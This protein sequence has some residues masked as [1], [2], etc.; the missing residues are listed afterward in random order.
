MAVEKV[1]ELKI[2]GSDDIE[3]IRKETALLNEEVADLKKQS[4]GSTDA[5]DKGAKK[6]SKSVGGLST[7]FKGLGLVLKSLGIGLILSAIA[8]LGSAFS[9]NQKVVDFFATAM[10]AFNMVMDDFVNFILNNFPKVTEFFKDVFENPTKYIKQLGEEIKANLN[11]RFE[12]LLEVA[13]FLSSA[14]VKLFKGDFQGALDSVKEAGKELVDAASGVDN[15]LQVW[16]DAIEKGTDAISNY[17]KGILETSKATVEL[18]NNAQLAAAQQ[19]LLVERYDRLAE[20]QRQIRDDDRNSID[21]RI[22]AN[23]ELS[24]VLDKQEK[25]ML[26]QAGM[27]IAAAQ[28]EVQLNDNIENRAALTDALANKEGVLAQIEGFRSEQLVNQMSLERERLEMIK[29]RQDAEAN[30]SFEQKKFDAERIKDDLSRLEELKRINAEET[31]AELIR[32][33]GQIDLYKVGTQARVDA[34]IEFNTRKQELAQQSQTIDDNIAQITFDRQRENAET[35]FNNEQESFALRLEALRN[36]NQMVL[37]SDQLTEIEKQKLLQDSADKEKQIEAQ[38]VQAKQKT[39]DDLISI[40]GAET[41]LGRALLIVKQG[42][43]LKELIMEAKKTITMGTLAGAKAT[44]ATAEGAAQ[45]AKV[46]FPQNIPLL[47]GYAAQ[48]AAIIGSV[49]SAVKGANQVASSL[50][51][52]GGSAPQTAQSPSFNVVGTSGTNQ[53]AQQLGQEQQPIQAFVVGSNVTTQQALDR[54]I[55]DTA[56]IG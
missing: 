14:L 38:R 52:G 46:G 17:A 48:A 3:K 4:K 41:K 10:E 22:A 29:S 37:D 12:S 30:L 13:G 1:I 8:E 20:K 53:I 27:Q 5:L 33:Q 31:K 21:E 2:K 24:N 55:V 47:I 28:R 56:T 44:V 23:N 9:R 45:T 50:G 39:L 19:G 49:L 51:G 15:S 11:E 6:S 25:A 32:L 18:R 26:A 16:G 43:A 36:F 40:A 35:F 42:L 34:E 54:N 7:T